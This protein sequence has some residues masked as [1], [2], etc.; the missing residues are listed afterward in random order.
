MFTGI[1]S[2]QGRVTEITRGRVPLRFEI[3]APEAAG[4]LKRGDS[5]AING[6]CL[7]VVDA[8]RRRFALD[9][10][11]ETLARSTLESLTKGSLVNIELPVRP[12]DRLGGHL[13]QGHVDGKGRVVRLEQDKGGARVWVEIDSDL[14]RYVVPKGSVAVDGV[15]LTV[16]D[17]GSVT[18]QVALIP[19]TLAETT[20]GR[21]QV[22][23]EVNIEV[24]QIAKYVAALLP[25]SNGRTPDVE[26]TRG[27]LRRR[28]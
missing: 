13:V 6:V 11:P 17:V 7:T 12:V 8:G 1:V 26:R 4:Q 18:F 24:D 19:H 3:K 25:D 27:F 15:S 10:V 9:V 21:L 2:E 14:L 5:V 22:G 20:L 28:S 23:S 16:A